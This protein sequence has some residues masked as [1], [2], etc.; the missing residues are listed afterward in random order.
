MFASST[1]VRSH[2]RH[3][4][5]RTGGISPT[6]YAPRACR[7]VLDRPKSGL[8][9]AAPKR[10]RN[11]S[12]GEPD[13]V[14]WLLQTEA[15]TRFAARDEDATR[16]AEL[17]GPGE[18]AE[19]QLEVFGAFGRGSNPCSAAR[20]V[21]GES[22]LASWSAP[23]GHIRTIA[24]I[25]CLVR[26]RVDG[27]RLTIH[28]NSEPIVPVREVPRGVERQISLTWAGANDCEDGT[29]GSGH[30]PGQRRLVGSRVLTSW[31]RRRTIG[32]GASS[33]DLTEMNVEP[34]CRAESRCSTSP[35]Y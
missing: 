18:A 5:A 24:D 31:S 29:R 10:R 20:T 23:R 33:P 13:I 34:T 25:R 7:S 26:P 22:Y 30:P 17:T 2:L 4:S 12:V 11:D 32:L 14:L 16:R 28:A 8:P 35:Q 3:R 9:P 21:V 19:R 6:S 27:C 1:T 15:A